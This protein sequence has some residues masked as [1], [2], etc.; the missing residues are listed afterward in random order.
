[1]PAPELAFRR[2]KAVYWEAIG[3]D[4]YG[5]YKRQSFSIELSVRWKYGKADTVDANG[6]TVAVDAVVVV[7]RYIPVG[8]IFYDGSLDDLA[9]DVSGT[10]TGTD[11][12][13]AANEVTLYEVLTYAETPDLKNRWIRRTVGLRRLSDTMPT[14]V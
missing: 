6:N 1:M 2:Q 12:V 14:S 7:D 4:E 3:F 9:G 10:G 13:P 11:F 8:S 5:Q